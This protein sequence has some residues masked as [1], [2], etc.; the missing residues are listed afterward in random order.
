MTKHQQLLQKINVEAWNERDAEP[1]PWRSSG[2]E[3]AGRTTER[4]H[5]RVTGTNAQVLGNSHEAR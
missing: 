1:K 5:C 3:P 4:T 2:Q